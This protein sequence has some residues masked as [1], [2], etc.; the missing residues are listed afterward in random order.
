MAWSY[1]WAIPYLAKKLPYSRRYHKRVTKTDDGT[2]IKTVVDSDSVKVTVGNNK[3]AYPRG[4]RPINLILIN[5]LS[6][7]E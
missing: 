7:G 2:V 3:G 5:S 1:C 4:L 6:A